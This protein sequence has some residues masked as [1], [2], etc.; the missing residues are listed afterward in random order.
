MT[1]PD[2]YYLERALLDSRV[3]EVRAAGVGHWVSGLFDDLGKL[4]RAVGALDDC[5]VYGTLN[6]PRA[7]LP[8]LNRF[9]GA[10]LTDSDIELITRL[11]LDFDPNRQA[12]SP[13]TDAEV[14]AACRARD[15]VVAALSAV[16]WPTPAIGWSG[17]GAHALYRCRIPPS[18]EWRTTAAALYT[19]L[20]DQF[21]D[22]FRDLG[23][24]FD[25]TVRNPSRI[26]R[27]YGTANRKGVATADRPHRIAQVRVPTTWGQVTQDQVERLAATL[28]PAPAP[29]RQAS[30]MTQTRPSGAGD[31]STL[32]AVAWFTAHGAYRR[33]LDNGKH[34]VI[35]PWGDQHTTSSATGTDTVIWERGAGGWPTFH[36]SHA[37]CD[38]RRLCDVMTLWGDADAYCAR[39]WGARRHG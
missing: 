8:V 31:Y 21:R 17:N 19:G 33:P 36:C 16:G 18:R 12:D 37:H 1:T 13:S 6:R 15:I 14:D 11:P 32:D 25:T 24:S 29:R 28:K 5:N 26:W 30:S 10:A 34:A 35:C 3:I 2:Y 9:G 27:L 22:Q 39:A 38:G 20:R 7:G 4:A 23:V